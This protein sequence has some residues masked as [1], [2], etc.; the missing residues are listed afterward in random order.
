MNAFL[1]S[2]SAQNTN[3]VLAAATHAPAPAATRLIHEEP[4][5]A[6]HLRVAQALAAQCDDCQSRRLCAWRDSW[7]QRQDLEEIAQLGFNAV[8]LPFG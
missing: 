6:R 4:A 1:L 3:A 8:R 5:D 2:N 7:L